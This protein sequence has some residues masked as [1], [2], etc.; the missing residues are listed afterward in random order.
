MYPLIPPSRGKLLPTLC[1]I[2]RHIFFL[3]AV[4]QN[5]CFSAGIA[6]PHQQKGLKPYLPGEVASVPTKP[7]TWAPSSHHRFPPR[8]HSSCF[9]PLQSS[10]P[11]CSP[12]STTGD[13]PRGSPLPFQPM[14]GFYLICPYNRHE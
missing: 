1:P 3:F 8:I 13:G 5:D 11:H 12:K 2:P 9:P 10:R 6:A 4:Q 7:I 14:L